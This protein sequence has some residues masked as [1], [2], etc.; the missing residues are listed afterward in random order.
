MSAI[1]GGSKQKSQ[2]TQSSNSQSTQVS[3][4]QAFPI[5]NQNYADPAADAY[6]TGTG[7]SK[8]LLGGGFDDYLHKTGYDFANQEGTSSLA[9]KY[10]GRGIFHSG[11]FGRELTNFGNGLKQTYANNY[12]GQLLALAQQGIAGGALVSGAGG[13]SNG[14]STA[15]STGQST[16][17]SSSTP[18]LAGLL[19]AAASMAAKGAA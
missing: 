5:I 3:G 8:Q 18:G 2:S 12:L 6:K 16:G 11:A 10:A 19:G 14:Q 7:L 1:F 17:S 15:T 13:Y 9:N 4:N